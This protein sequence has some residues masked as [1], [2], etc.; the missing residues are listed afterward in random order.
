MYRFLFYFYQIHSC[1]QLHFEFATDY[2]QSI[3]CLFAGLPEIGNTGLGL[4]HQPNSKPSIETVKFTP[5]QNLK[6]SHQQDRVEF[7]ILSNLPLGFHMFR[8]HRIKAFL[9]NQFLPF[10][11]L[12][13]LYELKDP[14]LRLTIGVLV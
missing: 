13:K 3:L 8:G 6:R 7:Q 4:F 9:F 1:S 11:A 12:L 10:L 2:S 14:S 5:H